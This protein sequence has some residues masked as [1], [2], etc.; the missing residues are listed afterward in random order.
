MLWTAKGTINDL[1]RILG[2]GRI[3]HLVV[4]APEVAESFLRFPVPG[5]IRHLITLEDCEDLQI[6]MVHIQN[7]C[8]N[9]VIMSVLALRKINI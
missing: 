2:F 3:Y 8:T 5:C 4:L 7:K 6:I 1:E 9:G